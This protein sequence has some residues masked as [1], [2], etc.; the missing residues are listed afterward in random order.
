VYNVFLAATCSDIGCTRPGQRCIVLQY[1]TPMST[2]M[3][4][5]T[6]PITGAYYFVPA[7]STLVRYAPLA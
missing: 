3:A 4:R 1:V 2:Q 6:T 7:L 5:F